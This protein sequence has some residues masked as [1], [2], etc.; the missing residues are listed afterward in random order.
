MRYKNFKGEIELSRLGM[1]NMRLP[2]INGKDGKI[3]YD[4][5]QEMIDYCM[6]KGINYYDTAY[7]YH[8][9]TSENFLGKALAKYPRESYFVADKYNMWANPN[10]KE[11]FQQQ[12][13][14]LQMDYIDFYLLHAVQDSCADDILKNGCIPYFD[15]LKKQGKIRYL[16]FSFH[17]TPQL[18]AK[19]LPVYPWDFVQI[20]LNYY[21]WYFGDAK[22]LYEILEKADIPVMVMEPVHGGLLANLKEE[23]GGVLRIGNE[24]ASQASWAMRWVMELEQVQ[25]V[26]SGMSD[27]Q[28]VEDNIRTFDQ[29][30][31]LTEDERERIERAAKIQHGDVV[32]ACTSCRY[33]CPDCPIGLD[34]PAL[35]QGYNKWKTE[36]KQYLENLM[37][38]PEGKRPTAC[39]GCGSCAKHCPQSFRIPEIME[40][41]KKSLEGA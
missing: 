29:A 28:Q 11:Q 3:D 12:L 41:M 31:P 37:K 14:R 30:I 32:V 8:E 7:V 27:Y 35:I 26:L 18:L 23:A 40:E 20:Q 19:M 1:G 10:Y 34:I 6:E 15:E 17:G 13:D 39:I 4:R 25:V 36:G 22:E 24:E 16:G 38:L 33:C 2:V 9:G 5:A 21:D